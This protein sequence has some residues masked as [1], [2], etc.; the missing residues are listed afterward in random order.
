ME[1]QHTGKYIHMH[2]F[3]H[4]WSLLRFQALKFQQGNSPASSYSTTNYPH[5][6]GTQRWAVIQKIFYCN[7]WA[8]RL[9]NVIYSHASLI[10]VL[11]WS[12]S[13]PCERNPSEISGFK[14]CDLLA[15]FFQKNVPLLKSLKWDP[16]ER[17]QRLSKKTQ[18]VLPIPKF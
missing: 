11:P 1:V 8:E 13:S 2:P 6:S 14:Q 16:E 18:Q 15:C 5:V 7:F 12:D 9:T 10:A 3:I 4:F 17:A